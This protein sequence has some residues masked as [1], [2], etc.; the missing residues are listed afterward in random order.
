MN[1]KEGLTEDDFPVFRIRE[2]II[3]KFKSN[4][5]FFRFTMRIDI[6]VKDAIITDFTKGLRIRV[7]FFRR[8]R[9]IVRDRRINTH[10]NNI[11]ER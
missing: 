2:S 4:F 8:K 7:R 11:E 9:N 6:S 1:I 3:E 5:M 10:N